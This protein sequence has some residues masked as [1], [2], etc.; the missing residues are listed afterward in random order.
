MDRCP[1]SGRWVVWG[2]KCPFTGVKSS[3]D[4]PGAGATRCRAW[5][6]AAG[7]AFS[8]P[9]RSGWSRALA[10]PADQPDSNTSCSST[11]FGALL[12]DVWVVSERIAWC[13]RS[14]PAPSPPHPVWG[15]CGGGAGCRRSAAV[16][17]RGFVW[18][19]LPTWI[20][21]PH[22]PDPDRTRGERAGHG[23][24]TLEGPGTQLPAPGCAPVL[25]GWRVFCR[26]GEGFPRSGLKPSTHPDTDPTDQVMDDCVSPGRASRPRTR[27]CRRARRT[28]T[29]PTRSTAT[30]PTRSTATA[31]TRST[32]TAPTRRTATAPTR[33]TATAPTHQPEEPV[34][35]SN[36]PTHR[37]AE[38]HFR[39]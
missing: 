25:F 11:P 27:P 18:R 19:T 12:L 20:G 21:G 14:V 5:A 3:P 39:G 38:P 8:S 13:S 35:P 31:P 26:F 28:A 15:R 17:R 24:V 34:I 37:P 2:G 4:D 10:G 6:L 9:G 1:R 33:R 36:H 22:S 29:A 32:A 30:A 23:S 16:G 7:E